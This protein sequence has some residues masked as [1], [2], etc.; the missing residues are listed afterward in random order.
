VELLIQEELLEE[1][2]GTTGNSL[3]GWNT[4]K[5]AKVGKVSGART[6]KKILKRTQ[7]GSNEVVSCHGRKGEEKWF[8]DGERG[9]C[10]PSETGE[11]LGVGATESK[12]VQK[13][14]QRSPGENTAGVDRRISWI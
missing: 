13:E 1:K 10:C 8:D 6:V 5:L 2:T 9:N 7:K 11:A 12:P 14:N 3:Q 4:S